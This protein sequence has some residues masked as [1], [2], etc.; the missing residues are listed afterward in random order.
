VEDG[1]ERAAILLVAP[2]QTLSDEEATRYKLPRPAAK[3]EHAKA[4]KAEGPKANKAA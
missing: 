3:A 2:G 4:N 1:D